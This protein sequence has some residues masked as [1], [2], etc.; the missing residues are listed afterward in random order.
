MRC[1][2]C[3]KRV[4]L[5][6]K[7][8]Q[9]WKGLDNVHTICYLLCMLWKTIPTH[10]RYEVS[11]DGHVRHRVLCQ[12]HPEHGCV[13][14]CINARG[15]RVVGL[16]VNGKS[17]VCAV[18]TLVAAAFVGTKQLGLTV[19][20]K[21]G[22]KLNNHWTNLEYCTRLE[23]V[24]HAYAKGLMAATRKPL[25]WEQA[26]QIRDY[27]QQHNGTTYAD[28]GRVFGISYETVSR[29]LRRIVFPETSEA[30]RFQAR[31]ARMR[32]SYATGRRQPPL[33]GTQHPRAALTDEQVASIVIAVRA[34]TARRT[35]AKQFGIS[36]TT[37]N[38]YIKRHNQTSGF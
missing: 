31:S 19:N 25:S 16:S 26:Q 20:H 32:L 14:G 3:R 11:E 9:K 2:G 17:K 27:A 38:L 13:A 18:A 29:V 15:Y 4:R 12:K 10:P 28:I 23:N 5:P 6:H 34:G 36:H 7:K 24:Q 22:N 21:D 35:L 1:R 8:F 33:R 30:A 37:V